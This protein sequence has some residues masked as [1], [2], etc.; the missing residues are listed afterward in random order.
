M[1]TKGSGFFILVCCKT[2]LEALYQ[3]KGSIIKAFHTLKKIDKNH[4]LLWYKADRLLENMKCCIVE[5]LDE[6][7]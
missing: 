3:L 1:V 7:R 6:C 2:L 5:Y 4:T